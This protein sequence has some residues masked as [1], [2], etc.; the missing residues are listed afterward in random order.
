MSVYRYPPEAVE[1]IARRSRLQS[2]ILMGI[3]F[4][5]GMLLG[6]NGTPRESLLQTLTPIALVLGGV[7]YWAQKNASAK[8]REAARSTEVEITDELVA[9]RNSLVEVAIPR[10]EVT[11]IR[12]RPDGVEV[13]GKELRQRLQ[14]RKD[15][16]DYDQAVR[17]LEAWIPRDVSRLHSERPTSHWIWIA[18]IVPLGLFYAAITVQNRVVASICCVA[19]SILVITCAILAKRLTPSIGSPMRQILLSLAIASSMMLRLYYLWTN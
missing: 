8:A 15:L 14:L 2:L 6:S 16:G 12:Y 3:L 11:K 7:L 4:A 18:T 13:A 1:R 5:G 10:V 17:E 9:V 19:F